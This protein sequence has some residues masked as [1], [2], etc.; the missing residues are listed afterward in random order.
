MND[1]RAVVH[2]RKNGQTASV[3]TRRILNKGSGFYVLLKTDD[4]AFYVSCLSTNW[5][6]WLPKKE[7]IVSYGNKHAGVQGS[8]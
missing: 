8:E 4:R 5:Q 3:K 2:I 6:G 7:V 1:A